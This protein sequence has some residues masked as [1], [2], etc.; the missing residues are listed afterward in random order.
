MSLRII[1][2]RLIDPASG[3][4]AAGDILIDK[5]RIAALDAEARGP[6]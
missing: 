6:S 4:D 5:G 3:R 2:A 1:N